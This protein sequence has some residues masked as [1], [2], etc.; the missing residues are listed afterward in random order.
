MLAAD[1]PRAAFRVAE[2][3]EA[4]G[5][6]AL[7]EQ[8]LGAPPVLSLDKWT[9]RRGK[10]EH[11]IEWHQDGAFLNPDVRALN[12]WIA[13]SACG[14]DAPSLDIVPRR[15]DEILPT[16]TDGANYSWSVGHEVATR[17][18]GADGWHRPRVPPRR[19]APPR[20][21]DAPP[22]GACNTMTQTRFAIETWFFAPTANTSP[23]EVPLVL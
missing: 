5:I 11:G 13:P 7:A 17:A 4:H 20:R 15:F 22:T 14:L 3:F 1:S 16:G 9:L 12:V 10:A 23:I 2:V 19:R 8:Y 6:D 21:Q 18:A